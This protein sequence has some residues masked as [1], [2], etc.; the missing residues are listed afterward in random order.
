[1]S[2]VGPIPKQPDRGAAWRAKQAT[3]PPMKS[4]DAIRRDQALMTKQTRA[5]YRSFATGGLRVS[6]RLVVVSLFC[7]LLANCA[8]LPAPEMFAQ[9]NVA[10]DGWGRGTA[11]KEPAPP[12]LK[13]IV[14]PAKSEEPRTTGSVTTS[15][16]RL[17]GINPLTPE[18]YAAEEAETQRL[19]RVSNICRC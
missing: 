1:M 10:S 5:W 2:G 17:N 18:L 11:E 8:A 7:A 13:R 4:A 19:K 9:S 12:K 14:Q 16:A 6:I 15:A 3:K